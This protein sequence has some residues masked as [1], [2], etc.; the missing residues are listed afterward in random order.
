MRE[1]LPQNSVELTGAGSFEE[2]A[3]EAL[4]GCTTQAVQSLIA[5]LARRCQAMEAELIVM[6]SDLDAIRPNKPRRR[7]VGPFGDIILPEED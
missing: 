7:K 6:R 5:R 3:L 2:I 1:D 4:R